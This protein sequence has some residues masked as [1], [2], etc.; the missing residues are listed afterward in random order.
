MRTVS[1]LQNGNHSSRADNPGHATD[2]LRQPQIVFFLEIHSL[3]DTIRCML[4]ISNVFR[5]TVKTGTENDKIRLQ[6][7][8]RIQ[9]PRQ[10]PTLSKFDPLH[11]THNSL[12]SEQQCQR[13]RND[14]R[15]NNSL[16]LTAARNRSRL[17]VPRLGTTIIAIIKKEKT[18][19]Q[20]EST[21]CGKKYQESRKRT[22]KRSAEA[23]FRD[24]P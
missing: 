21:P 8:P 23:N 17:H 1:T 11:G 19:L 4:L 5:A 15:E 9:T 13:T 7:T 22:R 16:S 10:F 20:I 12:C 6:R 18:R 14:R 2:F 3:N 24:L